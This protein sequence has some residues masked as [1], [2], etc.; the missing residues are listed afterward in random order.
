MSAPETVRP[1]VGGLAERILPRNLTRNPDSKLV[2]R[3]ARCKAEGRP[4]LVGYLPAGYP[5]V[6]ESVEAAVAL[7][8]NGADIIEIGIPYS[9]PVMDGTVIQDA[10]T[11]AL[12]NGVRVADAFTVVRAVS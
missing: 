3:I 12:A 7:G 5:T 8:Q 9:D 6:A 2:A 1:G 4:A 10:T 11:L